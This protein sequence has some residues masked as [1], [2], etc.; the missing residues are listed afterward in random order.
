MRGATT[1]N[2]EQLCQKKTIS[3]FKQTPAPGYITFSYSASC[4]QCSRRAVYKCGRPAGSRHKIASAFTAPGGQT[5]SDI[6]PSHLLPTASSPSFVTG[7]SDL[8]NAVSSTGTNIA[9]NRLCDNCAVTLVFPIIETESDWKPQQVS[10]TGE[11]PDS[12][13]NRWIS[14]S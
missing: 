1:G 7:T 14:M 3:I 11:L 6:M 9:E 13:K 12:V 5:P 8:M 10:S 4:S 2:S